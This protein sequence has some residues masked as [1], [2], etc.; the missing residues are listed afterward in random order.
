MPD[1]D[2]FFLIRRKGAD[3]DGW[4][5]ADQEQV[6]ALQDSPHF[7]VKRCRVDDGG[8]A[9]A[10]SAA[11]DRNQ[12]LI[13]AITSVVETDGTGQRFWLTE[14][15]NSAQI[16][17]QL[18]EALT[19]TAQPESPSPAELRNGTCSECGR[20]VA[21]DQHLPGC[22]FYDFSEQDAMVRAAEGNKWLENAGVV[23][24]SEFLL[25]LRQEGYELAATTPPDGGLEEWLRSEEAILTVYEQ[26]P[27]AW[28]TT[29]NDAGPNDE[30]EAQIREV[31]AALA[32][33]WDAVTDQS[34][35]PEGDRAERFVEEVR[36]EVATLRDQ[37]AGAGR[38]EGAEWASSDEEIAGAS[39]AHSQNAAANRLTG[40]LERLD[41][42]QR[43]ETQANQG[44]GGTQ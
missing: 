12:R 15:L 7:E 3:D 36:G 38:A 32:A 29:D 21:P 41:G 25:A 39:A 6:D 44:E 30:E 18:L 2:V 11:L 8:A 23:A 33:A 14:E 1:L 20:L 9:A 35:L 26:A 16:A 13:D 27:A 42:K 31:L 4:E 22:P 34:S 24:W 10:L 43:T 37:A 28:I 5:V 19:P 40:A 17:G